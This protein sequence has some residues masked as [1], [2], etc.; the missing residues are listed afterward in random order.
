[1][2]NFVSLA[3]FIYVTDRESLM[4]TVMNCYQVWRSETVVGPGRSGRQVDTGTGVAACAGGEVLGFISEK[5]CEEHHSRMEARQQTSAAA[6]THLLILKSSKG[7]RGLGS[8]QPN[9]YY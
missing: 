5:P 4:F 1:M 2:T 3:L 6:M 7:A 8:Q 9:Q